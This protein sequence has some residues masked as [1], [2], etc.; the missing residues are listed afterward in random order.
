[1]NRHTKKI[2]MVEPLW[3]ESQGARMREQMAL[4]ASQGHSV[5][6]VSVGPRPIPTGVTSHVVGSGHMPTSNLGRGWSFVLVLMRALKL[7]RLLKTDV[8]H[9]HSYDAGLV[10]VLLRPWSKVPL[11]FEGDASLT[12]RLLERGVVTQGSWVFRLAERI[13]RA[14]HDHAL[15]IVTRTTTAKSDLVSRCQVASDRVAVIPEAVDTRK[16]R[17]FPRAQAR[18]FLGLKQDE[19]CIVCM[20]GPDPQ[21][22]DLILS[23]MVVL[24]SR[25]PKLRVLVLNAQGEEYKARAGALGLDGCL[26]VARID[27]PQISTWLSASDVAVCPTVSRLEGNGRLF[28]S[29]ACAI[30]TV[31]FDT[32]V[33]RESLGDLGVF[34]RRDSTDLAARIEQV[35]DNPSEAAS[36]GERM[37]VRVEIEHSL[38]GLRDQLTAAYGRVATR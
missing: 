37:R 18:S 6:L 30:P 24:R 23:A 25:R 36:R 7:M 5:H 12:A 21:A 17:P 33:N 16:F 8:L 14:V 3:D 19:T 26:T 28:D 11:V 29:M 31:A 1:M 13:E 32:P 4:L 10:S 27:G 20:G 15:V 35:L 22:I 38:D 34:A 2:L 9:A